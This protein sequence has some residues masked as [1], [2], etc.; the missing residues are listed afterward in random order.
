MTSVVF[1]DKLGCRLDRSL[2]KESMNMLIFYKYLLYYFLKV[3]TIDGGIGVPIEA[4][5]LPLS[6]LS[7]SPKLQFL[8]DGATQT[9]LAELESMYFDLRTTTI[10]IK[11]LLKRHPILSTKDE[12][13]IGGFFSRV[14]RITETFN[15]VIASINLNVYTK[16]GDPFQKAFNAYKDGKLLLPDKYMREFNVIAATIEPVRSAAS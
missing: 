11:K 3:K 1:S 16:K 7:S 10:S 12:K 4:E 14:F 5:L 8:V 6:Q 13:N 2:H 15:D 9:R